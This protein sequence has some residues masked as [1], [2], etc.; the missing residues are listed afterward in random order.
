MEY[1]YAALLLHKEGQEINESNI[2]R[3][4]E[5]A[6]GKADENKI[7]A[8]TVALKGLDIDKTIKEA[9]TMSVA[10]APAKEEKKAEIKE[11]KEEKVSE[12]KAAAG[13]SALFG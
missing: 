6:G 5:A 10:S 11:E 13:L 1:M 7:K 8:V 3:V 12:E 9:A 2:R 4:I